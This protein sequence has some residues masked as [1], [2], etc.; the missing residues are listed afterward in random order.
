MSARSSTASRSTTSSRRSRD[1]MGG[2]LSRTATCG[3]E[4]VAAVTRDRP[5]L[6]PRR[7]FTW[8]NLRAAA[9]TWQELR[10]LRARMCAHGIDG[11]EAGTAPPSLPPTA[12][13]AVV[14]VLQRT[15]A[16][17]LERSV[18]LQAWNAAHGHP[19]DLIIG[20]TSPSGG[21]QAHAWLDGE[22][23]GGDFTELK[24]LAPPLPSA[25]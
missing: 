20:V 17:C 16:S 15:G 12:R 21:F 10:G 4:P 6:G 2:P 5:T 11:V 23:S 19:R 22:P 18:I 7:R 3:V 13:M 9:W 25:S 14:G 8:A 24:R 1:A